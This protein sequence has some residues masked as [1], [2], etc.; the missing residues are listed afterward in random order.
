[1]PTVTR[2][3]VDLSMLIAVAVVNGSTVA[4]R[5][6]LKRSMKLSFWH[7]DTVGWKMRHS[8]PAAPGNELLCWVAEKQPRVEKT[9]A[10]PTALKADLQAAG[11]E[12]SSPMLKTLYIAPAF[13]LRAHLRKGPGIALPN[14]CFT[15][16]AVSTGCILDPYRAG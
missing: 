9:T 2:L 3:D 6:R 15:R 8:M 14:S 16:S 10:A 1:M 13:I 4:T 11:K 7:I 12:A 5:F